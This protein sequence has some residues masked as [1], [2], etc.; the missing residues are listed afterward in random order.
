MTASSEIARALVTH[1]PSA[2]QRK[3]DAFNRWR[4]SPATTEEAGVSAAYE[5]DMRPLEASFVE[6]ERLRVRRA[7]LQ[8]PP[9]GSN[10]TRPPL[11]G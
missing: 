8:A 5:A 6:A 7:A 4:L 10:P 1:S 11:R 9:R 2:F 3:L